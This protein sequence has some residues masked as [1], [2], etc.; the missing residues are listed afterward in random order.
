MSDSLLAPCYGLNTTPEGITYLVQGHREDVTFV[1]LPPKKV[2][3]VKLS[4]AGPCP[5]NMP[6]KITRLDQGVWDTF[7]KYIGDNLV[8]DMLPIPKESYSSIPFY[9]DVDGSLTT[10]VMNLARMVSPTTPLVIAASTLTLQKVINQ[11][12]VTNV[13][14]LVIKDL[15]T[16]HQN[17]IDQLAQQAPFLPRK[18]ILIAHDDHL[19]VRKPLERRTTNLSELTD[20]DIFQLPMELIGIHLLQKH[21]RSEQIYDSN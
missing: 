8:K 4:S 2:F 7:S 21:V 15:K 11:L 9:Q 6:E 19:V 3:R 18:L 5:H 17:L 16:N 12:K 13:A 14:P 1:G 20:N 10:H